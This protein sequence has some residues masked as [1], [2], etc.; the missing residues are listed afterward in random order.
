M[1]Q[2][3][4]ISGDPQTR[5]R[6][7]EI[8]SRRLRGGELFFALP[9][10]RVDGHRFVDAALDAGA[11]GAV[12]EARWARARSFSAGQVLV[13]VEDGLSALHA[14]TAG[15]RRQMGGQVVGITGSAGKTTTKELLASMLGRRFRVA[16][17]PGNFNNLL[18]FP[19]ALAAIPEDTQWM[20]AEMGMSQPGELGRL[21][22]L[23]RPDVAVY[24]NVRPAHLEFFGSLDAIG[25]AKGEL[26]EGLPA[27]GLVVI[28]GDDPQ[29]RRITA[30]HRGPKVIY[31]SSDDAQV[32]AENVRPDPRG[33]SRFE[34]T[35]G[36]DRTPVRLRLHG[37]YNVENC[38]AAAACAWSLGVPAPEI[39]AAVEAVAP[40]AGRGTVHHRVGDVT[41][42]DDAYNAN[43]DA[44][45]RALDGARNLPGR[46]HWAVLGDMLELG[47]DAPEFHCQIG[48]AAAKRAFATVFAVGKL[49]R[50][51]VQGFGNAGESRAFATAEAAAGPAVAEL[52]DGDVVL[53]K[54]SRGVGLDAVVDALLEARPSA[55][56]ETPE[57]NGATEGEVN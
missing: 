30:E 29:V 7:V 38:L 13:Q 8:D 3:Q 51:V 19:I 54:G 22:R 40:V 37:P 5:C 45:T 57:E 50:D 48:E 33:G 6:G 32:R 17:S 43:P 21:S 47:P 26:L 15:I 46:R 53:V 11:A 52:R 23:A 42:I 39:A 4:V 31:G 1:M 28:N 25:N 41:I 16:R 49:A 34:L 18:G 9:G 10:E 20:V 36:E 44:V 27:D 2:G 12:V 56:D 55:D 35:L 24:T 14:L